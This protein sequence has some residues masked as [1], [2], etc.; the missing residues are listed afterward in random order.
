MENLTDKEFEQVMD[1]F[2]SPGWQIIINDIDET[3]QSMNNILNIQSND[4]FHEVKGGLLQLN[5][6]KHLKDWYQNAQEN[7]DVEV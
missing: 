5:W 6:F 3:Y 1:V 7:Q 4:D 2:A